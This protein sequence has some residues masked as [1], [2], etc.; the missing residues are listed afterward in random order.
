MRSA[1]ARVASSV[2]LVIRISAAPMI[3]VSGLRS[4]WLTSPVKKRSRSRKARNSV[5][6][7]SSARARMPSSSLRSCSGKGERPRATAT[8]SSLIG[9]TTRRATKLPRAAASSRKPRKKTVNIEYT[10]SSTFS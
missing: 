7:A 4:S 8:A 9:L 1:G 3:T 5:V 10:T 2:E 6:C